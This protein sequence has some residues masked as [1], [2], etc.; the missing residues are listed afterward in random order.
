[1]HSRFLKSFLIIL[2]S[3]FLFILFTALITTGNRKDGIKDLTSPVVYDKCIYNSDFHTAFTSL[4]GY[5]GELFIAFREAPAHLSKSELDKGKIKVLKRSKRGEW[6]ESYT[7][8]KSGIDLRDPFLLTFKNKL[9]IYTLNGFRAE[10]MSGYWGELEPIKHDVDHSV[11]LWK[12]R[13][14]DGV[15]YSVGYRM[16]EWPVLLSSEDGINW[17]TIN[18]FR[19][20]GDAT[21]AD[22]MF[23]GDRMYVCCRIDTPI[24]SQSVFGSANPPYKDFQWRIMDI[25]LACPDLFWNPNMSEPLL[26]GREYVAGER[27]RIDSINFSLYKVDSLGHTKRLH[28][29]NTGRLGDK[30]YSSFCAFDNRLFISYYCGNS[31]DTYIKIAELSTLRKN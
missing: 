7:F 16:K 22:I 31:D 2:V 10:Y 21:E 9:Y 14:K 23:M 15:L 27:N 30:G 6:E 19:I 4:S 25:S 11:S 28:T 18:T 5:N 17:T 1:M 26:A 3:G 12:I 13:E 29:F 24:G 8:S 20:G